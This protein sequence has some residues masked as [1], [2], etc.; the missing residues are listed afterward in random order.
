MGRADGRT[1]SPA[2]PIIASIPGGRRWIDVFLL[3]DADGLLAQAGVSQWRDDALLMPVE[4]SASEKA[5][6]FSLRWTHSS[7]PTRGSGETATPPPPA[8]PGSR[9]TV[10]ALPCPA[11]L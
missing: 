9:Q 1:R 3:L 10:R 2:H 4:I 6:R 5:G 8:P 11:G 7:T